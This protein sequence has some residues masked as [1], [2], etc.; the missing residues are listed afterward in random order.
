MGKKKKVIVGLWLGQEQSMFGKGPV[1]V[2]GSPCLAVKWFS[3]HFRQIL[4][5]HFRSL[6]L[7]VLFF[8]LY[9]F[10]KGAST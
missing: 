7:C 9:F 5:F 8:I 2:E 3:G 1:G 6:R 4:V 10:F